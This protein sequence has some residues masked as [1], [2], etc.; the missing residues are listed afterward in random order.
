MTDEE[1]QKKDHAKAEQL[2]Q[3]IGSLLS[4]QEVLPAFY[5]VSWVYSGMM[6][7]MLRNCSEEMK[8]VVLAAVERDYELIKAQA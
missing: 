2:M 4:G 3:T 5:A 1:T 6:T 8:E 7:G